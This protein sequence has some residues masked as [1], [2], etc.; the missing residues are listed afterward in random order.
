MTESSRRRAG[1]AIC[2]EKEPRVGFGLTL[3]VTSAKPVADFGF[4]SDGYHETIESGQISTDSVKTKRG[5]FGRRQRSGDRSGGGKR[6]GAADSGSA[7]TRGASRRGGGRGKYFSRL[8]R[9]RTR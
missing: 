6:H 4:N 3:V 8:V 5:S 2:V 1:E 7:R 9:Q